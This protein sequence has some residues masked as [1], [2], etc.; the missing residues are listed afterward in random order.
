[1][2][3]QRDDIIATA[4]LNLG[5]FFTGKPRVTSI[6]YAT[7]AQIQEL[8]DVAWDVLNR[9]VLGTA[10]AA[11][12]ETLGEIVGEARLGR[13]DAEYEVAIRGRILANR[14]N[15]HRSDLLRL[16]ELMRPGESYRFFEGSASIVIESDDDSHD[17]DRVV[18]D[19]LRDAKAAGVDLQMTALAGAVSDTFRFSDSGVPRSGTYRGFASISQIDNDISTWG[20][21][22]CVVTNKVLVATTTG[23]SVNANVNTLPSSSAGPT[24]LRL[25]IKPGT[26][27]LVRVRNTASISNL[28]FDFSNGTTNPATVNATVLRA[29]PLA[30]GGYECI[31]SFP[32]HAF[33]TF[34]I[35]PVDESLLTTA[36][37]TA[38]DELVTVE[39]VYFN[40]AIGGV[41][42]TTL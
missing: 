34:I 39:G 9:R 7:A 10:T 33:S 16:L 3:S 21:T 32:A 23:N 2:L 5:A 25:A 29:T 17:I 22:N 30:D 6:V 28:Y 38:G 14:S 37:M 4:V 27:D 11:Q 12:L 18:L 19:F 35:Q 8:E 36:D 24:I 20:A 31:A 13:T 26:K 15:G 42:R 40:D 1:M 41:F